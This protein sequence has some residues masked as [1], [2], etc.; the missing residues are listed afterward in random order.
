MKKF[1]AGSV[2]SIPLLWIGGAQALAF[3]MPNP[4]DIRLGTPAIGGSGCP[5]GTAS[6]VLSP[7]GKTLSVLFDQFQVEA[8]RTTGKQIDRKTCDMGIPVHVPQGFAV[9]VLQ[10]DYRGFN[11]LP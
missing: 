6:A 7:D 5:Q 4:S 9:S 8:G 1:V 3:D 10:V 2:C 11:A